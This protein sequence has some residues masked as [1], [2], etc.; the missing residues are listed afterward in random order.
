MSGNCSFKCAHI[1]RS[2]RA[3]QFWIAASSL[4]RKL[5]GAVAAGLVQTYSPNLRSRSTCKRTAIANP[6]TRCCLKLIT[7]SFEHPSSLSRLNCP[8]RAASDARSLL[9]VEL[10]HLQV[11]ASLPGTRR[12]A[13]T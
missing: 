9:P 5:H 1:S 8:A 7:R 13:S 10:P 12:F 2:A 6:K 4:R 11:I 3:L